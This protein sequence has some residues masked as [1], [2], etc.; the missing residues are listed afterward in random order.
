MHIDAAIAQTGYSSRKQHCSNQSRR[1]TE[2]GV[3]FSVNIGL[4][5]SRKL[6][7]VVF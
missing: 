4:Q 7:T 3:Y 5:L 6:F 1:C 2:T